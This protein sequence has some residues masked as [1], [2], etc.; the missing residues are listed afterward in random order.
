MLAY[1]HI[2]FCDSKCH[3]CSFNSYVDK[4][5]LRQAYMEA[6]VKQ[7][8]F[9]LDRFSVKKGAL[10]T[11]FI[12][13][14]TP[15]TIPPKLYET[16]FASIEPYLAQGAEVTTEA[17]PNSATLSWLRQMRH[18]GVNRISFGVQSF[19][20]SKLKALG[21]AHSQKEAIHAIERAYSVGYRHMNLD[22]IYNYQGDTKT[23]LASDIKQ[24]F[25]LPIDHISA[26]EL[27][28]EEQTKFYM[29]PEVRQENNALAF[30]V[31]ES[32]QAHGF[33]QY[34]ISNFGTYKSRH[35]LGYWQQKEYLGIG[36]G[37]VGFLN[38]TRFY[39]IKDIEHYIM[40]PLQVGEEVLTEENLLTERVFLGL[41]SEVGIVK[42]SLPTMVY[43]RAKLL[44]KENR[45]RETDTHFYNE[46][47]FLSDEVALFL[48]S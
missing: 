37:A 11:L 43:E 42:A 12:G 34:E 33:S 46:D 25:S 8:R 44:V 4:F 7:L 47:Y 5:E 6:L 24:A 16:F 13:G 22:L 23:L 1:I 28:I 2:P 3:Y 41:R 17:N 26:Y 45:L 31:A 14:G 21:R 9:E 20:D 15:S 35:N 39:G 10:E 36:A 27:T 40:N 32:I 18:F 19:D 48:L 38:G 29:T 30:Y